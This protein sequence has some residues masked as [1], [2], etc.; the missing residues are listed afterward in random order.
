MNMEIECFEIALQP[1]VFSHKAYIG[2]RRNPVGRS[3][4]LHLKK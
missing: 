2:L 4:K 1:G 3:G